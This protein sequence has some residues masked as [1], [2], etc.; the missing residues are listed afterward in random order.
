MSYPHRPAAGLAAI[1]GSKNAR[2]DGRSQYSVP[3]TR[4]YEVAY[5][6]R[7]KQIET[8]TRVAPAHPTFEAAF[9]AFTRGTLISTPKGRIAV[10][11]LVPGDRVTT[12]GGVVVLRWR[13]A[14]T[15]A[16]D[17]EHP[18]PLTRIPADSFGPQ[19]PSDNLMLGEGARIVINGRAKS[20]R[21]PAT[22]YDEETA[23]AVRP[24]TPVPLYHLVFDKQEILFANDLQVASYHPYQNGDPGLSGALLSLFMGLFPHISDLRDFGTPIVGTFGSYRT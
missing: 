13:G 12:P 3:P 22:W 19:R 14:I 9:S 6:S 10:E 21:P 24:V 20:L 16:P 17:P 1:K 15:L 18:A 7:D 11:D 5:L 2:P 23:F 8:A 4:F